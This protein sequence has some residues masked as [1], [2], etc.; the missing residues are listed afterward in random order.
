MQQIPEQPEHY[1]PQWLDALPSM[2]KTGIVILHDTT[3]DHRHYGESQ[4]GGVYGHYGDSQRGGVYCLTAISN[5]VLFAMA[6]ADTFKPRE[7]DGDSLP[8]ANIGALRLND[9]T[10]KGIDDLF[11]ALNLKW[12]QLPGDK[13]MEYIVRVLEKHYDKKNVALFL[14]NYEVNKRNG[15][16]WTP[17]AGFSDYLEEENPFGPYTLE[18]R[19]GA[20]PL[21]P[22]L[23]VDGGT[24]PA[25]GAL[26][27]H[28]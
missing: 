9:D 17:F 16:D 27:E 21:C 15:V 1:E 12:R 19:L 22:A 7:F 2:Q 5:P 3:V 18:A 14:R 23:S 28:L 4:R 20:M 6:R 11:L 24:G 25:P 26:R 10:W 8:T 13:D